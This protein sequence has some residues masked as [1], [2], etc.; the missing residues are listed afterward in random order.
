M[1]IFVVMR[2]LFP[3]ILVSTGCLT[4]SHPHQPSALGQPSRTSALL[5][6][7]DVPGPLEVETVSSADW[8]VD[9]GGLIDLDDPRAKAAGLKAG[10]EPIQV[11]FHVIRHPTRGTFIVD[12]GME[13]ALRDAPEK[14]ALRGL[15]TRFMKRDQLHIRVALGDWLAAHDNKLDG[16]F[17]THLHLDHIAGLPDVPRGTPIYVGPHEAEE[18]NAMNSVLAGSLDRA[19]AGQA[20]LSEWNFAPDPDGRFA[21]VVDVF[22]DGSLWAIATPGHTKGATAYL[23][24]TTHGPVLMTGDTC[25]TAWGWQHHVAP[26]SFTADHKANVDSLQR[27]Q[28]LVAEHPRIDVR[29]GHQ[30]L[31]AQ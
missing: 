17:M 20:P 4:T 22:G 1:A 27:L 14:A 31:A 15:V 3:L 9:R 16:V 18:R 10:D 8:V 24:R 11:F 23:A 2:F 25:H 5:S 29:L 6:V 28:Q 26:G 19:L 7:I 12:S 30:R 21:A 13:R